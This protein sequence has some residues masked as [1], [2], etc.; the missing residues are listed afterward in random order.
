MKWTDWASALLGAWL[1]AAPWVIGY[2][3]LP[4]TE[5]HVMGVIVLLLAIASGL[6]PYAV[7]ALAIVNLLAGLWIM[8]APS[9]L[10][11]DL[12]KTAASND[13]GIGLAIVIL[14]ALRAG[15]AR[16]LTEGRTEEEE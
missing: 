7:D 3:G 9:M 13:V 2:G 1:F 4:A 11:Y 8:F 5:A 15:T 12:L 16:L 10:G 14:E 6:V